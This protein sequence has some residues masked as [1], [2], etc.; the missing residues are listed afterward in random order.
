M[1]FADYQTAYQEYQKEYDSRSDMSWETF[2]LNG[3]KAEKSDIRD[4]S[5]LESFNSTKIV[6]TAEASYYY[7][8]KKYYL[9]HPAV[10]ES[11][12]KA[13][14]GS[15]PLNQLQADENGDT[16]LLRFAVDPEYRLS[17]KGGSYLETILVCFSMKKDNLQRCVVCVRLSGG[18][19]FFLSFMI[20]DK[21]SEKTLE[22]LLQEQDDMAMKIAR[23][24]RETVL[25]IVFSACF[26]I[27]HNKQYVEPD[28]L[29]KD[30]D[31]YYA[32]S[33]ERKEELAQKAFRRRNRE[34][35]K[36][37]FPRKAEYEIHMT[38]QMSAGVVGDGTK[39]LKHAHFRDGHWHVVRYGEGKKKTKVMWYF[40]NL[41]RGDLP[42]KSK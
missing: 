4:Q 35:H 3:M 1:L 14:M 36:I 5:L 23:E 41:I 12:S 19:A 6:I 20:D 25:R 29:S 40:M 2:Y 16:F 33:P 27:K 17:L 22:A 32:A 24:H 34:G 28:V 42:F 30:L 9:I 18:I 13:K 26:M 15:V 37:M 11:F 7:S 31:K 38:N 39:Q 21:E 10:A 8:N